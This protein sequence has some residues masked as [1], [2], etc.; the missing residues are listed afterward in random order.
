MAVDGDEDE[1]GDAVIMLGF[2]VD[3]R[4]GGSRPDSVPVQGPPGSPGA[5]GAG[6]GAPGAAMGVGKGDPRVPPIL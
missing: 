5:V 1:D 6:A 2:R 3:G 4:S